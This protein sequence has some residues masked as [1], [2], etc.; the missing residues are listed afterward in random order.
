MAL[1]VEEVMNRELFVARPDDRVDRVL[2][3]IR[4]LGITAAPV[5]DEEQR[6][7]GVIS[8]R[9]LIAEEGGNTVGERMR[10]PAVTVRG[11]DP[12]THAACVLAETRV[13]HLPVVD[14]GGRVVGF[15]SALDLLC[16]LLGLPAPIRPRFLMSTSALGSPG[17]TI[18][19]SIT[20][21]SRALPMGLVCSCFA[22]RGRASPIACCSPRR[23]PTYASVFSI[24][25]EAGVSQSCPR[26]SAPPQSRTKVSANSR[27]GWH[28][29]SA[30]EA[31]RDA[32]APSASHTRAAGAGARR[33]RASRVGRGGRG[34]CGIPW[35]CPRPHGRGGARDVP[36]TRRAPW[37]AQWYRGAAHRPQSLSW[38]AGVHCGLYRRARRRGSRLWVAPL[39]R[40]IRVARHA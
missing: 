35:H 40:A 5:L 16:G 38:N 26:A 23:P 6:P 3:A 7:C 28:W 8:L 17:P 19:R 25:S 36:L 15:L 32:R 2:K 1:R 39:R 34:V 37:R 29:R 21:T 30:R 4:S 14:A 27:C 20:S 12:I 13:H 24:C 9:D 22:V 11:S 10:G 18:D 31:R 33:A